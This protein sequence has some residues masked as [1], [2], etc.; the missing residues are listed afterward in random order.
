[1]LRY[2]TLPV[3]FAYIKATHN[4]YFYLLIFIILFT[5]IY[6]S[7]N[8]HIDYRRSLSV[9]RGST[10]PDY[11]P[12]LRKSESLQ[13]RIW[14]SGKVLLACPDPVCRRTLPGSMNFLRHSSVAY[15]ATSFDM[16]LE[17]Y[18]ASEGL[19]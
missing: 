15:L 13:V 7:K 2:T 1:M 5:F 10:S 19:I 9:W 8:D 16:S 17:N 12:C 6:Y 14:G 11:L 3:L 18:D 4:V